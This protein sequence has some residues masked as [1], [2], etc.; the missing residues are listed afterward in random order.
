MASL[1]LFDVQGHAN[2]DPSFQFGSPLFEKVTLK[3]NGDPEKIL[4]INAE[5]QSP[6]N[7]YIQD[8]DL[9]G[10][11]ISNCWI[12]RKELMHGGTLTFRMGPDP[13]QEWGVGEPPP[14]MN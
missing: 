14:S 7:L 1:G 3:L 13:N 6:E 4:T 10:D 11:S 12:P 8:L 2:A 9:N 5:D